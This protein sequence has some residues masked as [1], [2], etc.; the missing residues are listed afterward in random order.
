MRIS[1]SSLHSSGEE[2]LRAIVQI[3]AK[4]TCDVPTEETIFAFWHWYCTVF[5]EASSYFDLRSTWSC[6]WSISLSK[7]FRVTLLPL[8]ILKNVHLVIIELYNHKMTLE[9]NLKIIQ[10]S[11][12]LTWAGLQ[13]TRSDCQCSIRPGL[14]QFQGWGIHS[15][16]HHCLLM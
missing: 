9:G 8:E 2:I 11:N 7:N 5:K 14:E 6:I 3:W 10:R 15:F 12:P 1:E 4:M 13:I 16:F